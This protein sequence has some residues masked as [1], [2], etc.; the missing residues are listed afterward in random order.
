MPSAA[1]H[2]LFA[3]EPAGRSAKGIAGSGAV[4]SAGCDRS[5][6]AWAL[7]Q[8]SEKHGCGEERIRSRFRNSV[9]RSAQFEKAHKLAVLG[10]RPG[11]CSGGI[12]RKRVHRVFL[13][14][15]DVEGHML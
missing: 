9:G 7:L 6:S 4:E 15:S 2:R 1:A 5:L 13:F 11:E 14:P 10:T 3:F 8:A 12:S